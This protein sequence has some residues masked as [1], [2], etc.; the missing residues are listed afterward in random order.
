MDTSRSQPA[1]SISLINANVLTLDSRHPRADWVYVENGKI[2]A[3]GNNDSVRSIMRKESTIIDCKGDTILPGLIDP[4]IHL[5]SLARSLVTLNVGPSEKVQSIADL[6]YKLRNYSQN[7]PEGNWIK[8]TGYNEFYLKEKRHPNRWDLDKVTS[9]HPIKLT[10]R[11]SHAHVL[12]SFALNKIGITKETPDPYGGLIERNLK[13]GEP[14]GLL[15]EMGDFLSNHIP[16][17]DKNEFE[18]GLQKA[19]HELIAMGITT[20]QDASIRNNWDQWNYYESLIN[21][22]ILKFRLNIMMGFPTFSRI[23]QRQDPIEADH[24]WLRFT[25]VKIILDQSSG[26]LTPPQHK[27]NEMVLKVHETGLQVAIHAI[28]ENAIEAACSAIEFALKK[29]PKTNHRHRIEHCSV[30]PPSLARRLSNI[31]ISVVTQPSFIYYNGERYRQTVPEQQL[32]YLYPAKTLLNHGIKVAGSSDCPIVPINPFT[33]IYAA[34]T[35][36]DATGSF[37]AS[38]EKISL[39]D[40][41]HLYTK[42]AAHAMFEEDIKGTIAPGKMADFIVLQTDPTQLTPDEIKDLSVKMTIINGKIVW[43][44]EN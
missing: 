43:E 38:H 25:T 28:E 27:L 1:N 6:Q 4:H 8:A 26:H 40:A 44:K 37:V 39:M 18:K 31:N 21:R 14:T 20:V 22:S 42:N 15:Y 19:N 2:V 11:T 13:D 34:H 17:L 30:C 24:N 29:K 36:L 10:H 23:S 7:I 32:K 16:Q 12:N 3:V 41:L 33:A 5:A 9:V 35:R